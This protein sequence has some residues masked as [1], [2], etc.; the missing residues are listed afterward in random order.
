MKRF[1]TCIL[2]ALSL[3]VISG[4][5]SAGP[6]D[7]LDP[8]TAAAEPPVE[9][10]TAAAE[11]PPEIARAE[12]PVRAWGL[13]YERTISGFGGAHLAFHHGPWLLDGLVALDL[14]TAEGA[15]T[16]TRFGGAAAAFYRLI[17]HGQG[18]L[19]VG[20]R[21]AVGVASA[22]ATAGATDSTTEIAVEAPAR[23]QLYLAPALAVHAEAGIA[24]VFAG[25]AGSV[26]GFTP[27]G[28]NRIAVGA[29]TLLGSLGFTLY[30][31]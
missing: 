1:T 20:G 23:L 10:T 18:A 6:A 25:D 14:R 29:G 31:P 28:G 27:A 11:P 3:L 13:G 8:E 16:A 19:Y 2:A 24:V 22:A 17:D 12:L 5:V 4:A 26:V 9:A 7:H 15:D 30:L 21:V